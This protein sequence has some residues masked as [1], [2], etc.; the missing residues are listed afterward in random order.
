MSKSGTSRRRFDM[1]GWIRLH[2][3]IRENPIFNDMQLFRLWIIC[4]TEATYKERDQMVGKQL[5]HLMPGEFVTGRF[6]LN[7]LYNAGLGR[8]E[9]K[10]P[11]TTWRWLEVLESNGFVVIK[12]N[13]KYSVVSIAKW[14]DYQQSDDQDGQQIG[15][16][17]VNNLSTNGQQVVTN[18]KVKNVNNP[19]KEK[20]EVIKEYTE[21]TVEL[22]N[23]LIDLMQMNNPNVKIPAI[24]D[25]WNDEMEKLERIDKYDYMQIRSII[26]W[27][28]QDSFWKGNIL[29][30]PKLREKI[31]TLVMQMQRPKGGSNGKVSSF[32]RLQQMAREEHEREASG[33]Y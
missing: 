10:P 14:M 11:T 6:S 1:D 12:S 24:L 25:K 21:N 32:A 17:V 7:E 5:A 2:R 9:N 15:Q 8:K 23:H 19:K 27:C 20:E 13:N 22:T 31:G 29:S 28:Q 26:D 16:Q 18:K 3:K 30:V 4:L 33:G